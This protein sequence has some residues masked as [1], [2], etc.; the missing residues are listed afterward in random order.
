MPTS[1]RRATSPRS[2]GARAH[3]EALGL[4]RQRDD[5]GRCEAAADQL[6]RV[7]PL[8]GGAEEARRT[9]PCASYTDINAKIFCEEE[10]D[11]CRDGCPDDAPLVPPTV[12]CEGAIKFV[13]DL[14]GAPCKPKPI[15]VPFHVP[16]DPNYKAGPG[17]PG[18]FIDGVAPLSYAV[19]FENIKTASGDAF[20]V[21]V[22]DQLEVLAAETAADELLVTTITHRHEDRLRSYDLLA[23][24]WARRRTVAKAS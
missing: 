23:D 20:E 15:P 12:P 16:F 3:R 8:V 1:G 19:T 2:G 14:L 21:T 13:L 4:R 9:D 6:L 5:L 22:T 7:E 24:E 18:G 17:G 10:T 11:P